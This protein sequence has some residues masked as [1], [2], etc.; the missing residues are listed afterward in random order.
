MVIAIIAIL[1]GLLLPAIQKVRGGGARSSSQNSMSQIAKGMHNFAS[2]SPDEG[3][4]PWTGW[5]GTGV[6]TANIARGPF[7][8][9]LPFCEQLPTL[10]DDRLARPWHQPGR[11]HEHDRER[12]RDDQLRVQR[13]VAVR[14][15][16]I[17]LPTNRYEEPEPDRGQ[18]TSTILLSEQVQN[19]NRNWELLGPGRRHRHRQHRRAER[20]AWASTANPPVIVGN[21]GLCPATS[22]TPPPSTNLAP[23]LTG[24]TVCNILAPSSSHS[25]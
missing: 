19:C 22:A 9:I 15:R 5:N 7:A 10:P 3:S 20:G 16:Q 21:N 8:A 13:G 24:R 23:R 18:A 25:I 12:Q 11:L 2:A 1:I 17:H 4:P 14:H 6:T